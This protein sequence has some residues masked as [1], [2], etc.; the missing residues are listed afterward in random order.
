MTDEKR[1]EKA[2]KALRW[3][4]REY[5][6]FEPKKNVNLRLALQELATALG[7]ETPWK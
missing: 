3:W 4:I 5:P 2:R 6:L 7:V 1:L